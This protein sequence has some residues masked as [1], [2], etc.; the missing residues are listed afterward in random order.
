MVGLVLLVQVSDASDVGRV[1]FLLRPG[2]GFMLGLE[3]RKYT[4]GVILDH[5]ILEGTAFLPAFRARFDINDAHDF[6]L[7]PPLT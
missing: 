1:A 4:I 6:L 2:D 5:V 7:D 3:R